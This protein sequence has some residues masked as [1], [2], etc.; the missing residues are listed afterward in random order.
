MNLKVF[1]IALFLPLFAFTQVNID[2][3]YSYAELNEYLQQARNT[4]DQKML[5]DVYFLLATYEK[6]IFANQ[7]KSFDYF[8]RSLEFYKI[9]KDT[10]QINRVNRDIAE[11]Y[12]DAGLYKRAI[13]KYESLI[14]YY[15][16][17]QDLSMKT[18]LLADL[19]KV[20]KENGDVEKE[21]QFLNKSIEL[22]KELNDTLLTIS[23]LLDKVSTYERLNEVDSA[24]IMAFNAF[25]LADE[26][27][28]KNE[29]S[30]SLYYIG[31]LNKLKSNYDRATKYLSKSEE[32]IDKRPYSLDRLH[33]YRE[34]SNCYVSIDNYKD[35]HEYTLRYANLNDSILNRDKLE[36]EYNITLKF[37]VN[38][39]EKDIKN[40]ELEKE[41]AQTKNN[42]QRRALYILTAGLGLLLLLLYYIV[43]FYTQKISTEKIITGQKQEITQQKIRELE[44]NIKISSM[45]SMLE[46]QEIERQ[47]IAKDLH[48]SLGGL[49]STIKLQFD[50]VQTKKNQIENLKEYKNAH[51]LLDTAVNEVR[52]ISQ[53]LQPG[54]LM[55]LGLIPALND[56][57]NRFDDE[58]YPEIL[59]QHY[60]IPDKIDTMVSLSVYRVIQE[61]L[62]NTVKHA[63]ASEVLIQ[64][65]REGDELVI[66]YEDDG[67][68][69]EEISLKRK[70]MGLDNIRSRINYLKGTISIDSRE[71]EG[72][73]VLIRVKFHLFKDNG[74]SKTV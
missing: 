54:S 7:K 67:I 48:D 68:G 23:F 62:N 65:D 49:L 1:I 64:L 4:K 72:I 21:L 59:L 29:L 22:N 6:T 27:E 63:K 3:T 11:S 51:K 2:S 13:E 57:I 24:L 17:K 25:K 10:T 37:E 38:E 45:Q 20:Y 74:T 52:S 41:Y 46:G 26:I 43:R 30:K 33:L 44:D 36:A 5:A 66:Q 60:D 53:N 14:E 71:N 18:H 15:S 40:L 16:S 28:N 31:Y 69:F 42:Q 9:L 8:T 12:R 50:S 73:S 56:L 58:H 32:L 19:S 55:S 34:L 35:A 70:G 61:L 39:K 47:R